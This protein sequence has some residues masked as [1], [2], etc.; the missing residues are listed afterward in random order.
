MSLLVIYFRKIS[1]LRMWKKKIASWASPTRTLAE[2]PG[3]CFEFRGEKSQNRSPS[4]PWKKTQGK[5]LY[6]FSM[7]A[8]VDRKNDVMQGNIWV[9]HGSE[10]HITGIFWNWIFME[11]SIILA[12]SAIFLLFSGGQ[13]FRFI[14]GIGCTGTPTKK[15]KKIF[16]FS[17][18]A[19]LSQNI[20]RVR[21]SPRI[22]LRSFSYAQNNHRGHFTC[23]KIMAYRR[24]PEESHGFHYVVKFMRTISGKHGYLR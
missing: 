1:R 2:T 6:F 24:F 11:L 20:L 10:L 12:S 19:N 21:S 8:C 14:G 17:F 16:F 3:R 23:G 15:K 22:S 4:A 9:F 18:C 5:F 13:F 7:F